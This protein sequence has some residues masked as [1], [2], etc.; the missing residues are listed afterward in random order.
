MKFKLIILTLLLPTTLFCQKQYGILDVNKIVSVY[1]GDTFRAKISGLHPIIGENISIRING[2]DTPEIRTKNEEIK[3]MAI[4]ARQYLAVKFRLAEKLDEK[5]QL[6]N[7]KRGKY[8]RIIA[9][10]YVDDI[11]LGQ[12]LINNG[13]ALPYDGGKK[14]DWIKVVNYNREKI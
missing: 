7:I 4:E 10:V 1:D 8:F 6:R 11:N 2:I 3:R 14:P 12:E 5:I 13:R 9:D